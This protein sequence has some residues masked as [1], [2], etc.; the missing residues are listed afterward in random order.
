MK[1]SKTDDKEIKKKYKFFN[2]KGFKEFY[3]IP[4]VFI[5]CLMIW[6]YHWEFDK[7]LLFYSSSQTFVSLFTIFITFI[8]SI[9]IVIFYMSPPLVI[10]YFF[11]YLVY[12]KNKTKRDMFFNRLVLII[13]AF[14][15]F[16]LMK[17]SKII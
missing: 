9:G 10:L 16:M 1:D 8:F 15:L 11:S 14:I 17:G 5:L 4:I 2:K 13:L 6:L 12:K 7:E 3:S